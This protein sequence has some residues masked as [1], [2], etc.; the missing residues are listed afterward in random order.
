MTSFCDV[1]TIPKPLKSSTQT[2]CDSDVLLGRARAG[3]PA[4]LASLSNAGACTAQSAVAQLAVPVGVPT[5][6]LASPCGLPCSFFVACLLDRRVALVGVVLHVESEGG[7]FGS[8]HLL[9]NLLNRGA[10]RSCHGTQGVVG[11]T[12]VLAGLPIN[13][14]AEEP[15]VVAGGYRS[16]C[17]AAAKTAGKPERPCVQSQWL[18]AAQNF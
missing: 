4:D 6:V 9:K 12:V 11:Q 14:A 13:W 17:G 10:K 3:G 7:K 18:L 15:C 5:G 16:A 8:G 2:G 1:S